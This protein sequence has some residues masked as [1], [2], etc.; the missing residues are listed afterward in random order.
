MD[1]ELDPP[2]GAA[3]AAQA[4]H[5][6]DPIAQAFLTAHEPSIEPSFAPQDDEEDEAECRVC[7][8][9]AVRSRSF[10]SMRIFAA[11]ARTMIGTGSAFVCTLQV[12]R[13]HPLHA[14]GLS[15]A[16]ARALGQELLRAMQPSVR[17]QAAV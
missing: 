17:V 8:G 13:Q 3:V 10:M 6:Q 9:E 7:R 14:R 15:G 12:Q 4:A 1:V 5:A 11:N 2:F 16:M